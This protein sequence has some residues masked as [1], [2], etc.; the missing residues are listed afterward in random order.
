MSKLQLNLNT[1]HEEQA[2]ESGHGMETCQFRL[3]PGCSE[4]QLMQAA[5][6]MEDQFLSQQQGFLQHSIFKNSD[7]SYIDVC[8]AESPQKA[9][10]I[11]S[12]WMDDSYAQQ[13]LNL[14]D[15]S[16]ISLSLWRR[17]SV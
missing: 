13:F 15:P 4:K 17:L 8:C 9:E 11:Y 14:L 16:S 6:L 5:R 3:K 10:Q 1:G 2:S 12:R 7:G